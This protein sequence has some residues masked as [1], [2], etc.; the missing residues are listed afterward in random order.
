MVKNLWA[1][2]MTEFFNVWI[3]K[4]GY[5]KPIMMDTALAI[6][7]IGLAIPLYYFGK[8]LRKLTKDSPAH[9]EL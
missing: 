9:L 4:V 5:I 6:F 7:F 8:R 2:G 1:Y 3:A